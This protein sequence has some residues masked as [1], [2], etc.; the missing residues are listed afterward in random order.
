MATTD[1][2]LLLYAEL[3]PAEVRAV[4]RRLR[5][6][7]LERIAPGMVT[8]LAADA[9]PALVAR[10]RIRILAALYPRAVMGPRR[11]QA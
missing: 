5:E 11:D 10:E 1:D 8:S 4:Q 7:S 2:S 9:W 6:G 3:S